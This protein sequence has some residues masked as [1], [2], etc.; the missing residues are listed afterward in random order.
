[1]TSVEIKRSPVKKESSTYKSSSNPGEASTTWEAVAD[2]MESGWDFTQLSDEDFEEFCV[3]IVHD[4]P[5]EPLSHNRAQA[6]LPRNLTLRPSLI[7]PNNIGVWSSDH[8]PRGTRFGPLTGELFP[9]NSTPDHFHPKFHWKV[10]KDGRLDHVIQ[11]TDPERSSWQ[12]FLNVSPSQ[13]HQNLVA[14]Q[15]GE[16]IYF[17]TVR[18]VEAH[19]ELLFWFSREYADRVACPCRPVDLSRYPFLERSAS[20]PQMTVAPRETPPS[21]VDV[22]KVY[23][24]DSHR[25]VTSKSPPSVS[26]GLI[27]DVISPHS[28]HKATNNDSPSSQT[29]PSPMPFPPPT[30]IS[31]Q[32]PPSDLKHHVS[33]AG[34]EE[35]SPVLDFSIQRKENT[36]EAEE[37]PQIKEETRHPSPVRNKRAAQTKIWSP[38]EVK[39]PKLHYNHDHIHPFK[40]LS[41]QDSNFIRKHSP[42]RTPPPEEQT[43]SQEF[44]SSTPPPQPPHPLPL[45]I[46]AR[47]QHPPTPQSQHDKPPTA[48]QGSGFKPVIGSSSS[49]RNA[50]LIENLLVKKMQEQGQELGPDM[51]PFPVSHG[52]SHTPT[53]SEIKSDVSSLPKSSF[54]SEIPKRMDPMIRGGMPFPPLSFFKHGSL[55]SPGM[56]FPSYNPLL[57]PLKPDNLS[58]MFK[59]F[60]GTMKH[61]APFNPG[62]MVPSPS[63]PVPTL[64][65]LPNLF[66]FNPLY[67]QLISHYPA[68]PSWP[69]Y[70]PFSSADQSAAAGLNIIPPPANANHQHHQHHPNQDQGLNLTKPKSSV[71]HLS[72]GSGG[73]GYRNLPYPL[74]K[75]DGKMHYE[76]NVCLKTFGQL[77]NLKVHL[78]THTGERPFVCQTCGKGFTQ[79][80]HLQ[81][82]N[83]VHTGEKP[84]KCQVC[85]KRFSSTSNLKT[86]MRLHSGEKPF[87]CKCCNAKFTQ[88]V[89]LK[90][91]RRLHTNERPF[92]CSQCNRK[93]ISRSGLKTHWKTGSCVPQNPAADFNTLMN[94]SFDDKDEEKSNDSCDSSAEYDKDIEIDDEIREDNDEVAISNVKSRGQDEGRDGWGQDYSA[95]SEVR[96]DSG[97][98]GGQLPLPNNPVFPEPTAADEP[99]LS[100]NKPRERPDSRCD[101]PTFRKSDSDVYPLRTSTPVSALASSPAR[102]SSEDDRRDRGVSEIPTSY[103][104]LQPFSYPHQLFS[105]TSAPVDFVSSPPKRS[106]SKS[107]DVAAEAEIHTECDSR[108]SLSKRLTHPV[109]PYGVLQHSPA[110]AQSFPTVASA[111]CLPSAHSQLLST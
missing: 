95:F 23:M 13:Q 78:R 60:P 106:N 71:S 27:N 46:Q 73:R 34:V 77:S 89:H 18:P 111:P 54:G 49:K 8:I 7:C 59:F 86:H 2:V 90:L 50:G 100:P 32:T 70:P 98:R 72:P 62:M 96:Q 31:T 79:L 88:F 105:H 80:A 91:H 63:V 69:L 28:T 104:H 5:C 65:G 35:A 42:E 45:P 20:P 36:H 68:L 51:F 15:H 30:Y 108:D 83:L 24:I 26:P 58:L 101:K 103:P 82:H 4:R 9:S 75:K 38:R 37:A 76:C 12:H 29:S 92:E 107:D 109:F 43:P 25:D 39:S 74:K 81:K 14:C 85:D 52:Y 102:S 87:H 21:S 56:T 40:R 93:Y 67:Q 3:Y 16:H 61:T 11:T 41:H 1:M 33:V 84:H 53:I 44:V 57:N 10:Y 55:Y 17:Y 6:S 97:P 47:Q 48:H 99:V 110:E 94:M 64:P 22:K 19:S 66:P